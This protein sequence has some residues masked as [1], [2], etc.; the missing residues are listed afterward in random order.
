[1]SVYVQLL[2]ADI[3]SFEIFEGYKFRNLRGEFYDKMNDLDIALGPSGDIKEL[4]CIIIFDEGGE[5]N[6]D[7]LVIEGKTYNILVNCMCISL[8]YDNVLDT[9]RFE[10]PYEYFPESASVKITQSV[11]QNKGKT[12]LRLYQDLI[13]GFQSDIDFF[14][15]NPENYYIDNILPTFD[16]YIENKYGSDPEFEDI[17]KEYIIFIRKGGFQ[18]EEFFYE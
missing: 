11:Q 2:S 18:I 7:D 17:V 6:I 1:M 4:E 13:D 8:F 15:N 12:Y 3:L 9:I 10:Y 14:N 5:V 16:D